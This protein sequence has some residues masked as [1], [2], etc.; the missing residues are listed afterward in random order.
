MAMCCLITAKHPQRQFLASVPRIEMKVT[1][2]GWQQDA[3]EPGLPREPAYVDVSHVHLKHRNLKSLETQWGLYFEVK[4]L[5]MCSREELFWCTTPLLCCRVALEI[6]HKHQPPS[7]PEDIPYGYLHYNWSS[8]MQTSKRTWEFTHRH[9]RNAVLQI[10][11]QLC[12]W[13]PCSCAMSPCSP[14]LWDTSFLCG[15]GDWGF[16]EGLSTVP[17]PSSSW[18][19]IGWGYICVGCICSLWELLTCPHR[20]SQPVFGFP[21]LLLILMWQEKTL[22][23]QLLSTTQCWWTGVSVIS[24]WPFPVSAKAFHRHLVPSIQLGPLPSAPAS[25]WW[26][27]CRL[28]THS[29]FPANNGTTMLFPFKQPTTETRHWSE[30]DDCRQLPGPREEPSTASE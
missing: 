12:P 25:L 21:W 18:L 5:Y 10:S 13:A 3:P 14:W 6:Q 26:E 30:S 28:R 24:W 8:K 9:S 17:G 29:S 11:V 15:T 4:S 20:H 1:G 16:P 7:W 19:S 22:F 2:K 23:V 27:H